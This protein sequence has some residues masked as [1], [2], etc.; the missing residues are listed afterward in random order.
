MRNFNWILLVWFYALVLG[1]LVSDIGEAV[2]AD[3]VD[4]W[5]P[6]AWTV[7]YL[8]VAALGYFAGRE[9]AKE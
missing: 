9:D 6:A 4:Y 3:T 5:Y 7:F 1:G 8:L 2:E